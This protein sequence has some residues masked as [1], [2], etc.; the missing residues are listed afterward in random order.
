MYEHGKNVALFYMGYFK[1]QGKT[2]TINTVSIC[3]FYMGY[4]KKQGKT[5]C[6][7][8]SLKNIQ[9]SIPLFCRQSP[10][11]NTLLG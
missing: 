4:F 8:S 10:P 1:K 9:N 7:D 2:I 5:I 11:P 6:V 3:K